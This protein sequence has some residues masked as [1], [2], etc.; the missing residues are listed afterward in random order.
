MKLSFRFFYIAYVVVLIS[1]GLSGIFLIKSTNDTLWNMQIEQANID[2][3]YAADSFLA[4]ADIS[5]TEMPEH[6]IDNTID[7]IKN[8]LSNTVMDVEL[9][10]ADT[11]KD[12]FLNL[13][14]NEGISQFIKENN[15]IIFET[16]CNLNVG[17]NTYYL[18]LYSDFTSLY[19]QCNSFWNNYRIVAISVYII[20]GF[21][22]F[23]LTKRIVRPLNQLTK[24]A[25]EIAL[26]NYGKKAVINSSDYEI[27]NLSRSFNLM[28]SAIEQ[29]II[30]IKEES[31]KRNLFVADFTHE[32]K[33]PMTSIIGYSQMLNSYQ[34]DDSERKEAVEAI[35]HEA[36]RLEKLSLQLL[37]LYVFQNENIELESLDLFEIGE[38]LKASL[39]YLSEKYGV[40]FIVNFHKKFVYANS[41][42][43]L[44]LLYN[45]ADNAFKASKPQTCIEIYS[46]SQ[47]DAVRISVKDKGRGIA[48]ENIKFV[49][50]PFFREDKSR[51]RKY[52]GAGLGL[53][54]CK[55]IVSLH[56]SRLHFESEL[57]KGTI[58]SFT[59][60]KGGLD[61]E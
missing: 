55:E 50:E 39:K 40:S 3:K 33:T 42:L 61:N 48:K 44:S 17:E 20:S 56:G 8:N 60:K 35:H 32:L 31:E 30:E 25:D 27:A 16:L 47:N 24:T 21:L 46:Q 13:K 28:S 5:Y 7:Q 58:V 11:V 1:V 34:L 59:L 23:A 43:L 12:E 14:D 26:G 36:T 45:L 37:D 18:A 19:K 49:T 29:K 54:L 51:S 57:G 41:A 9:Y 15:L 53:S 38:Q 2:A 52:G 10:T 22:L 4:L 6:W